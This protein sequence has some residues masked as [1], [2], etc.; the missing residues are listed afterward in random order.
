MNKICLN[1]K[2]KISYKRSAYEN[3]IQLDYSV[4]ENCSCDQV[5]LRIDKI[6]NPYELY[7]VSDSKNDIS[8]FSLNIFGTDNFDIYE[9]LG[10]GY[11]QQVT[12]INKQ[13]FID[14]DDQKFDFPEITFV[15]QPLTFHQ[16][17]K[18]SKL[19]VKP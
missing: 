6:L 4:K 5:V 13:T 9:I 15:N 10:N 3:I 11:G 8:N 7:V 18:Q 14:V 16:I 2:P 19:R 17:K 12:Q 1:E